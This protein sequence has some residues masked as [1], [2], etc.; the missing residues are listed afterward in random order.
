MVEPG[1][2]AQLEVVEARAAAGLRGRRTVQ[3]HAGLLLSVRVD[4]RDADKLPLLCRLVIVLDH[5]TLTLLTITTVTI[6]NPLL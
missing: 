3:S 6:S 5:I 4:V 1:R 2:P